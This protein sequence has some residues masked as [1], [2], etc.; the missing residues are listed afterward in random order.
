MTKDE[1]N[2]TSASTEKSPKDAESNKG[3]DKAK[4]SPSKS[5]SSSKKGT[6]GKNAASNSKKKPDSGY[7]HS[8]TAPAE[9]R[10]G[11]ASKNASR[12]SSGKKESAQ[13]KPESMP[14]SKPAHRVIPCILFGLAAF[15]AVCMVLNL[16]C[17]MGNRCSDDPSAHLMGSVG[18]WICYL[19]FGL[20]GTA[21]LLI[22]L[23]MIYM[24]L[25]WKDFIDNKMMVGKSILGLLLLLSCSG[26]IHSFSFIPL[27]KSEWH[28]TAS[29]LMVLGAEMRGG[30]VIGGGF[31]YILAKYMNRLGALTAG[32]VLTP[33]LAFFF[34]GQSP[35]RLIKR[36]IVRAK[37]KRAEKAVADAD[38]EQEEQAQKKK[39]K[40]K[41]KQKEQEKEQN[42]SANDNTPMEH[43]QP[44]RKKIR[45]QDQDEKS[46]DD[47]LA[48]MP[49]PIL[50]AS[51]DTPVNNLYVP[52]DIGKNMR[53]GSA[54]A[55]R[56]T[57]PGV[58]RPA[59]NAGKTTPAPNGAN[60]Q[61]S[62]SGVT[63]ET[64]FPRSATDTKNAKRMQKSDQ[65]FELGTIFVEKGNQPQSRP[66]GKRH[67]PLPPEA[68]LPSAGT[69][70]G[71]RNAPPASS[72]R[73]APNAGG[74]RPMGQT[75]M[76][77][78]TANGASPRPTA[79]QAQANGQR[80]AT[81]N[82][83][84]PIMVRPATAPAGIVPTPDATAKASA[85]R[86]GQK[87]IFRPSED[88]SNAE[89]GLSNEEFEKRE[90]NANAISNA[91]RAKS[92]APSNAKKS[93]G[94]K[95]QTES[96]KKTDSKDTAPAKTA[97]ASS[98]KAYVF[99]PI[100]YLH[101]S[102]PMTAENH[103]E[104]K[105]N[106][107]KLYAT[108]NDFNVR[109]NEITY[110][111]GPTVTRYEI[112]PS[113]G[114]RVRTITNLADDIAL[115]F[116]VQSV[117]ME[118]IPGKSAIGV[119]VPNTTRQTVFLRELLESPVFTDKPSR[120]TAGLGADVA[121][122]PLL[123]DISKMPHLLVAG[124][125]GMG[126]SVCINC[127]IMSILFKARPDQVKLILVD[128][129]KVEFSLYKGI[130]HLM[131]PIIVTPKDA[132]GALQ[133]A[134]LEMEDRFTKIQDVGVSNIEG[135]N[136]AAEKDPDLPPMPHIVI[137]IDE[138]A[139]LMLTARDEVEDSICRLAQK[140]RAA[141][142]HIIVGTQRPSVDVVTGL[143]KSNIPSRVACTVASQVDS[144]T[145][146]DIA[147]A[148][149]LLGKGDMLFAPVGSM[150]PTRVQGAFVA[151]SEVE[152]ICEF[153]R[154]TNGTAVYNEAFTSKMKEYS[155]MCGN[156][157]NKGDESTVSLP[158]EGGDNKYV[159]AIRVSIEENRVS[160]SLLQRKL[161]IGYS[162]AA[163][164][165]DRMEEEGLVS[166]A[167]GSKPRNILIS[168]EQFIERYIEGD[169]GAEKE[170]EEE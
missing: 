17:N 63:M 143:I 136:K 157:K 14:S 6:N 34:V 21:S 73:P 88:N 155:A 158:G 59:P 55:Q 170:D 24:A 22:P 41:E 38:D 50:D 134:V 85:P 122:A 106:M 103:S 84:K 64:V 58:T 94:D 66:T 165:I 86:S 166:K 19:F 10:N 45:P 139:D 28:R 52:A 5:R 69:S 13:S 163:K 159:D 90:A 16:F 27:D 108:L 46:E 33:L 80:P 4:K 112:Y 7:V 144:R 30:G 115:A 96:A 57:T 12:N 113:A 11:G 145:I 2:Q 156:K 119:E 39:E 70:N 150:K 42:S 87:P 132:A 31:G 128:P 97:D 83:K 146:L 56:V 82:G 161:G 169:A 49:M 101:P 133:A 48:P 44:R 32:L 125:T 76:N 148:E 111:C 37:I 8:S 129:K 116:A 140:A 168:A 79:S 18:Y 135:Y 29:E 68:P 43:S 105:A 118:A 153:I 142:M 60:R 74:N 164:I 126:K 71:A 147:G 91:T 138:L 160:T 154:A 124:A 36:A 102:E 35:I 117:R 15:L 95:K 162:R 20:F 98:G 93:N 61:S 1:L 110:S 67:A 75:P 9:K 167:D 62:P 81:P 123:F 53:Q 121:G 54:A 3:A 149:K 99:P 137:I 127:I 72:Q 89:Y 23:M 65:N 109:I 100:S 130:P 51:D 131:A 26:F 25:Y 114:V 92:S 141:G 47:G 77:G 151:D 40:E 120:L 152:K 104:I 107:E 78:A